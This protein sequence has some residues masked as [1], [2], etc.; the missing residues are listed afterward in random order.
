MAIRRFELDVLLIHP[1]GQQRI[2]Q[3]LGK[4]LSAKEPPIQA[5]LYASYLRR[6][7]LRVGI[8]DANALDLGTYEA[9][10][11]AREHGARL[12]AIVVYGHNPNA[13]TQ[14]MPAAGAIARELQQ[15]DPETPILMLGGH[16]A[17]LPEQTLREEA[18]DFVCEG[19]GPRTLLA[20][21]H[22][23]A[24]RA[25]TE[26]DKVPGLLWRDGEAIRRSA[27]APLISD[28]DGEMPGIAW[29]M[30]PMERYRAHNW[31]CFGGRNREP[32]AAIYTT[33]G[34]PFRCSF[35][36][37]QAPFKSGESAAGY[38][39][40][41][42]SYRR[43]SPERIGEELSVLVR[44]Y[45]VHNIKIAD[46]LF[47][48]HKGH[49][50][51]ICDQ[52]IAR[53]LDLNIWAYARVDTC[54]DPALLEKMRRA[55]VRW[56]AIGIESASE[57][58]RDDVSKGYRPELLMKTLRDVQSSGI[59]VLGNYI[60][61]LPEDDHSSMQQTLD[62]ALELNSEYA[63]F[64]TAMAYPG[65]QLYREALRDR[66]ELPESWGG[67]AQFSHDCQPLPTRHLS[68]AEV[69]RFRD[70]AFQRYFDRAEYLRMA[71][72]VLGAEAVDE[73]RDMLAHP[74]KRKLLESDSRAELQV[75]GR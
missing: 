70:A 63:N 72:R 75:A 11:L 13:S 18:V 45:G 53:G 17:A 23:L 30:L 31:H 32:Y 65:S 66:L 44:E 16:V 19:E 40:N 2:Y 7:G 24:A 15:L 64:Y 33:L 61:G 49:V 25:T 3:A 9:A 36:C 21:S 27:P 59:H 34:C 50:E 52:I 60:F 58:V 51:A 41:V 68:A 47:V 8:L 57:R 22:A 56:L 48:L 55:G 20:L 62:F 73:V 71:E 4:K 67:Y 26:L 54:Q 6:K 35:C 5:G 10:V 42:N 29:D 37:I 28:L 74:L 43:W 69:L 38:K 39:P 12:N 1:G 46:E 14:V